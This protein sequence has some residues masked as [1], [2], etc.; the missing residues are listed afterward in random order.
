[1]DLGIA[2]HPVRPRLPHVCLLA[3][4][5]CAGRRDPEPEVP[6]LLAA[7][8]PE[9]LFPDLKQRALERLDAALSEAEYSHRSHKA[10][11]CGRAWR[12]LQTLTDADYPIQTHSARFYHACGCCF[13]PPEDD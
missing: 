8:D 1:M 2:P 3:V 13:T 10:D 5:G 12:E 4:L 9:E 7:Q 11:P 6:D